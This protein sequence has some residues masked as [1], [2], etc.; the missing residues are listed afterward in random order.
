MTKGEII[1][2][3]RFNSTHSRIGKSGDKFSY[4][5]FDYDNTIFKHFDSYLSHP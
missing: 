1:L 3:M 4:Y 5:K 2:S